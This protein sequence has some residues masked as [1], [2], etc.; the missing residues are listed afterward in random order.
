MIG[1]LLSINVICDLL[2][3]GPGRRKR[4]NEILDG[5]DDLLT[6]P[7]SNG[8]SQPAVTVTCPFLCL[9]GGTDQ[10]RGEQVQTPD[11][12]QL[13]SVALGKFWQS[14]KQADQHFEVRLKLLEG[15]AKF[16][17]LNNQPV[18]AGISICWAQPRNSSN[19]RIPT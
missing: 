5:V 4:R 9:F 7:V 12:A 17:R 8:N 10:I 14:L 6:A 16:S 18:M 2:R 13:E 15:R 19:F 11:E 3:R 1:N